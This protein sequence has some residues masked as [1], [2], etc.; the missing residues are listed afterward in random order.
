MNKNTTEEPLFIMGYS[1]IQVNLRN[2]R[3]VKHMTLKT[4]SEKTGLSIGN[5]SNIERGLRSPTL[6][7]LQKICAALNTSF[8][9]LLEKSTEPR[10]LIR[11]DGRKM[12]IDESEM[13]LEEID[14]G[15]PAYNFV[16]MTLAPD[17]GESKEWQH[18]FDEIG[19]VVSGSM[20]HKINGEKYITEKGDAILVRRH[21]PHSCRN[22]SSSTPCVSF[23]TRYYT[24]DDKAEP[25][26]EK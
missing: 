1:N 23:W 26:K 4:L 11:A 2:I 22:I 8:S 15:Q 12:V 13:T 20:E 18:D 3:K 7:N 25:D 6:D 10:V 5:L 17:K 19:F 9:D 24:P 16:V 14:F 21:T